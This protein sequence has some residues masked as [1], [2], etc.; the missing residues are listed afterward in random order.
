M[1]KGVT[2]AVCMVSSE[3]LGVQEWVYERTPH[4]GPGQGAGGEVEARVSNRGERSNDYVIEGLTKRCP[5]SLGLVSPPPQRL[6]QHS[7]PP[8]HQSRLNDSEEAWRS[9]SQLLIL[10][11]V[12]QHR[13][14]FRLPVHSYSTSLTMERSV[15]RLLVRGNS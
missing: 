1:S 13:H 7:S 4:T 2:R 10:P 3:I 9:D 12:H 8:A 14:T 11:D 15:A 5:R 6:P